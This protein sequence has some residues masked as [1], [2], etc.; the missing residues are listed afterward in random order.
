MM[1][2]WYDGQPEWP[3]LALP[4]RLTKCRL[5][6]K[7]KKTI[8]EWQ[9]EKK[10]GLNQGKWPRQLALPSG[11]DNIE[12]SAQVVG[13]TQ[14]DTR[15]YLYEM[16]DRVAISFN[17]TTDFKHFVA[18]LQV[19]QVPLADT[20]PNAEGEFVHEGFNEAYTGMRTGIE[21]WLNA[22]P[23]RAS[24][25]VFLAGFSMG[26][27]MATI[28]AR[29]V[30]EMPQY[31][32]HP[33][34]LC[35]VT[36]GSPCVGNERFATALDEK[37]G[38]AWRLVCENDV[39][40]RLLTLPTPCISSCLMLVCGLCMCCCCPQQLTAI[41]KQNDKYVHVGTE[42]MICRD[43][44]IVVAPSFVEQ[45]YLGGKKNI[46]SMQKM[47][48]NHYKYP[49]SIRMWIH[50]MHRADEEELLNKIIFGKAQKLPWE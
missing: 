22:H 32:G 34:R 47:L 28:C 6:R 39:V 3:Q 42:V 33:E 37:L 23:E 26:A 15:A 30:A 50:N 41:H 5:D 13:C 40:P 14:Y 48:E 8:T 16:E 43:G 27:A 7:R 2:A 12:Y 21:F 9:T 19:G 38:E 10:T 44:M 49:N 25:P 18:D 45:Q 4:S 20:L 29:Y 35:L 24:K 31:A 46:G 11:E 1:A 17:G 36:F